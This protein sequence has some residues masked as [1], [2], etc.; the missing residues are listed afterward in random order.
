[1]KWV[2]FDGIMVNVEDVLYLKR[3]RAH[4]QTHLGLLVFKDG[5]HVELDISYVDALIRLK[6]LSEGKDE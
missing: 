4:E 2:D 6:R 1:M 5:R 3:G